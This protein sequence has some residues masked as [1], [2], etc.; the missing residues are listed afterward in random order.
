MKYIWLLICIG[1]SYVLGSVPFGYIV[2][3]LWKGIDIRSKGSGNIGATN[4]FR[5]LGWGPALLVLCCDL[6]KGALSVY[7][8]ILIN[9]TWGGALCGVASA[10]GGAYSVFLRFQ[11]GKGIGVSSGIAIITMPMVVVVLLPV[12]AGV[13]WLTRYVSLGSIIV[14]CLA[15]IA[16]YLLHYPPGYIFLAAA[17]GGLSIVR[18]HSNIKRLISG[19][20][21]KLG[22][23]AE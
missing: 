15:P 2:G 16:A 22:E 14:A 21:R 11:G 1:L 7:L 9:G 19:E 23:K 8:G 3:K 17:M 10:L 12:W 5:T 20:E 6:G 13:I 4:T 18:H